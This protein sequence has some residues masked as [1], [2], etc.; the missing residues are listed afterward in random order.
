MDTVLYFEGDRHAS[1]RIL[2]AVKNR[3]GS[4]N[5]IGVFEMQGQALEVS[6]PSEYLLEGRPENASD[7]MLYGEE[8]VRFL[9]K[10][11]RWFARAILVFPEDCCRS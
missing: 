9:K 1:Y 2:R 6:N 8:H 5:E 10:S 7:K 4:T 11:R 3:F